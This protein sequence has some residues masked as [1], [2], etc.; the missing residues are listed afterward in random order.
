MIFI[1][2]DTH[3]GFQRFS[4]DNFPQQKQMDRDD[5]VIITGDFGGVWDDS[6]KEAYWLKRL[7]EKPFTT[8]FADG[9]HEN[10]DRLN[11][12][13]V[14][15]WH[16]GKVHCIRPHILHLMRGQ[17]FEI[18]GITF[19]TMGGASSHDIQDGV[20][21]LRAGILVQ[22]PDAADVSSEGRLLVSPGA[23]VGRGV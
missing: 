9:N 5:Y 3:G 23:A 11:E 20:P 6:P 19:F 7:E 8:L 1:T 22:T 13:P 16:G 2:G 18:N 21:W 10:F 17:I 15:Q 12:F 4:V 14:Q